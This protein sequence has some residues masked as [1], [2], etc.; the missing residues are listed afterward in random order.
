MQIMR[1]IIALSLVCLGLIGCSSATTTTVSNNTNSEIVSAHNEPTNTPVSPSTTK[2]KWT[3]SGDPIDV[4]T[5]NAE[6]EKA[7]KAQ[8]AKPN[9]E[10]LKNAL[11]DAY[12]QRGFALTEARQY[13]SALGDYRRALKFNPKNIDAEEWVK[14]IVAIYGSINKSYPNEGEEPPPLPFGKDANK[15]NTS[16]NE[17]T[18][19]KKAQ[20]NG[21]GKFEGLRRLENIRH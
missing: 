17:R 9:D 12:F 14:K 2:S 5:F 10:A 7:E 20:P 16:G 18:K 8:K 11:S 6:I 13:A 19:F 21:K 3:Q 1:N 4:S 15:P